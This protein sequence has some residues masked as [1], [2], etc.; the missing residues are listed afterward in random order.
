T[1]NE[2]LPYFE[3]DVFQ[4]VSLPYG[5]GEMSMDIYLP[6]EDMKLEAFIDELTGENWESWKQQFEENEGT[7]LLP[8]FEIEYEAVLNDALKTLGMDT[9]FT[10]DANFSKMIVED[11][12]VWISKV[13][14][15]TYID[16]HEKG[17]EAAAVTSVEV[18]TLALI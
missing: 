3:N 14:Q 10:E 6:K 5:E 18:E 1:L 17:T 2:K 13:R 12:P 7:I 15:K 4:A 8:K 9:V 11:D 16:V